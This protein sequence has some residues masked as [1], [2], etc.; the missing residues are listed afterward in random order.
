MVSKDVEES[1]V[2]FVII[3]VKTDTAESILLA[4]FKDILRDMS[5]LTIYENCFQFVLPVVRVDIQD[6]KLLNHHSYSNGIN[7]IP[8]KKT[9]RFALIY[10]KN[11]RGNNLQIIFS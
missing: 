4:I 2:A 9:Y 10:H 3:V 6:Y 11:L 7:L 8:F 1:R 5:F